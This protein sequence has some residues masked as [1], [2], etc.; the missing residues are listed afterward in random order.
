MSMLRPRSAQI[1]CLDRGFRPKSAYQKGATMTLAVG[2]DEFALKMLKK[3]GWEQYQK[4]LH[5]T[6][7]Y[8]EVKDWENRN[9][10]CPGH[11]NRR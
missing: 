11:S 4:Y 3:F 10:A 7:V 8:L 9:K 2:G 6:Y 1:G 5:T